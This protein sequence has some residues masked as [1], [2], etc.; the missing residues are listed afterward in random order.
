[1]SPELFFETVGE[2]ATARPMKG[3]APRGETPAEDAALRDRLAASVKDRA[4]NLMI[5][6]LMRNDLS[7]VA[8]PGS[9]RVAAPFAVETYPTVHQM[10]TTVHARLR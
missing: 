9:V 7:R 5:V 8:E 1:V 2:E 4:E 6:D 10:V 3:T